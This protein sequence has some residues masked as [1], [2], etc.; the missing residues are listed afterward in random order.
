[1]GIL[2]ALAIRERL[3]VNK[4]S[5]IMICA[6]CGLLIID[7]LFLV[8]ERDDGMS[9]W[10]EWEHLYDCTDYDSLRFWLDHLI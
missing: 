2:S 7:N 4:S 6:K 5:E 10:I 9:K 1:M 8:V 3:T